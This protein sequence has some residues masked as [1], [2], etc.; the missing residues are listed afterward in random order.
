MSKEAK[1]TR[2]TN[3]NNDSKAEIKEDKPKNNAIPKG[4]ER[5]NNEDLAPIITMYQNF[6]NK[7]KGKILYRKPKPIDPTMNQNPDK[8]I[9][10]IKTM[11]TLEDCV[12]FSIQV[13]KEMHNGNLNE[14]V[15]ENSR[16][17]NMI[18][19]PVRHVVVTFQE[20]ASLK[21]RMGASRETKSELSQHHKSHV[22]I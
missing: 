20:W 1:E 5:F 4:K 9:S 8:S 6:Y 13:E 3:R 18:I 10:S 14:F 2:Q 11:V 22:W 17:T 15:K 19:S 7:T 12:I 16:A 21:V